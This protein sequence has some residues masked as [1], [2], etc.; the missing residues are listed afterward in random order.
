MTGKVTYRKKETK[1]IIKNDPV[2]NLLNMQQ[3]Y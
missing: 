1:S 3:Y 2:L